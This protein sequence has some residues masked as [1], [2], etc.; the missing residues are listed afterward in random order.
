MG[1]IAEKLVSF[2]VELAAAFGLVASLDGPDSCPALRN[3]S[4]RPSAAR[5]LEECAVR[6]PIVRT[7]KS[8]RI[9]DLNF[10]SPIAHKSVP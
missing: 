10:D 3:C 4:S 8:H 6:K 7:A 1:P 9:M 2:G 5:A